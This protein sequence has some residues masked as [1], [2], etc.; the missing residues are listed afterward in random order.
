M[1][2]T[3]NINFRNFNIKKPQKKITNLLKELINNNY[4][5]I[6]SMR[7]SYKDSFA[8]KKISKYKKYSNIVLIGMGGSILGAKA[9][10]NFLGH[11]IKKKI[12]ISLTILTKIK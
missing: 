6:E 4:S 7:N 2:L 12:S 10:Y 1:K 5:I 11:K 9:I 8:K 3:K